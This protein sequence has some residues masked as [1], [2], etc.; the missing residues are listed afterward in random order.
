MNNLQCE[1]NLKKGENTNESILYINEKNQKVI[2]N[3]IICKII[4]NV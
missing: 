3:E 2:I 4:E 1:H